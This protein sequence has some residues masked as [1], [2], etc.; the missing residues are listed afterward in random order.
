MIKSSNIWHCGCD[1]CGHVWNTKTDEIPT[2]CP[3]CKVI[4]W[5]KD[6]EPA[7]TADIFPAG[8]VESSP[9]GS[10]GFPTRKIE[11]S[12]QGTFPTRK[13]ASSPEGSRMF[14]T[15]KEASLQGSNT[16][17]TG[18]QIEDNVAAKPQ[19]KSLDELR[20]LMANASSH[21]IVTTAEPMP[22]P[23]DPWKG[24]SEERYE[25]NWNSGET[26]VYRQQLVK[27]FARR[28]IRTEH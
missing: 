27:P 22:E 15:G 3:K 8:N 23:A 19:R 18:K 11:P 4:T 21:G 26:I 25:D 12:L 5:N 6:S 1:K 24:W 17:P 7:Q 16:F 10:N 2:K 28:I 9:Q 13:E 14:P 20:E